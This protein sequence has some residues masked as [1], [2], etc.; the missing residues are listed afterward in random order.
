MTDKPEQ[1]A[2]PDRGYTES[3]VP[4]LEGV[5]ERI[6]TRLG[7][8]L[9]ATELAR[10]TPEAQTAADQYDAVHQ[11]AAR[12]LDEIRAAMHRTGEPEPD[13]KHEGG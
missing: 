6:E 5:R 13:D 10:E 2:P 4:T 8:A 7:T 3:G 11:A 12:R 9:G 1:P